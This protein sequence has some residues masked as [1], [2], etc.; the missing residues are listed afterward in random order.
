MTPCRWIEE[1]TGWPVRKFVRA[2][3]AANPLPD[4]L[5]EAPDHIHRR[6]SAH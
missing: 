6:A 4:D 1:V 3:T 2:I 5:R